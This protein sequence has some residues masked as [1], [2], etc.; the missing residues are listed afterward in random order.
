[1]IPNLLTLG[2]NRF[3]RC[4]APLAIQGEALLK[5]DVQDGV[6]YVDLSVHGSNLAATIR[7]NALLDGDAEITATPKLVT[8]RTH[9]TTVLSAELVGEDAVVVDRLDLR[10][11]GLV[12]FADEYSL[13]I[14]SSWIAMNT[15][16]A[17]EVGINMG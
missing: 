1:M 6:L 13:R 16:E 17:T 7:K 5:F 12:I 10:P 15:I 11:F 14:G 4:Q 8:I 9:G 2:G 3:I